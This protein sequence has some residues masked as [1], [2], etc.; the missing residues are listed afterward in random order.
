M[1]NPLVAI[2]VPIYNTEQY[3]CRCIDSILAQTYTCFELILVDDGSSDNSGGICQ[4]YAKQDRRVSYYYKING[5]LSDA[6]NFG[7][8]HSSSNSKYVCFI[9]SDDYVE[10][11]YLELLLKGIGSSQLSMCRMRDVYTSLSEHE[12]AKR[13]EI[14]VDSIIRHENI[15]TNERFVQR[16]QTG[17]LN[18]ACNKLYDLEII[19]D[20][21][22][23]FKKDVNVAEDIIFNL[24]YLL[25]CENVSEV[26]HQLYYYCHRENSLV[27]NV[28]PQTY[29]VYCV[30]RKKMASMFKKSLV[31]LIDKMIYR[32]FESISI[33]LIKQNKCKDVSRYISRDE[34]HEV[35]DN[36]HMTNRNDK[37]IH[38]LLSH[39]MIWL[40]MLYLKLV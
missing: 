2:V 32:Q 12:G 4:D 14:T 23:R 30:I 1:N 8:V 19:R 7:I 38:F 37:V 35:I 13:Y 34:I 26:N 3:L 11:Q 27:S 33:K 40:L 9:D 17:I 20:N 21:A 31:P 25:E 36:V 6:R 18:S 24:D 16:F 10:P 29:D 5:G 22:L 28:N 15:K 39:N